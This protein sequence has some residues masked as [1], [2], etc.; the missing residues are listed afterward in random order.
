M[1]SG[2]TEENKDL[3]VK[4]ARTLMPT[5]RQRLRWSS[6]TLETYHITANPRTGRCDDRQES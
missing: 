6:D 4:I 5:P 3:F 1:D 2:K